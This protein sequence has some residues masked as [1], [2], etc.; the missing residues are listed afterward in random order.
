M[1][2]PAIS[3]PPV[4]YQST[5]ARI[6]LVYRL[7]TLP[8]ARRTL[9]LT[10]PGRE[11]PVVEGWDGEVT[12]D[13]LGQ[14]VSRLARYADQS[15]DRVVL[16]WSLDQF[17]ASPPRRRRLAARRGVL[18]HVWRILVPRGV[19]AGCVP[20]LVTTSGRA[21][22]ALFGSSGRRWQ[23]LLE[24]EGFERVRTLIELPSG[25]APQVLVGID[26][27][28]SQHY[29]LLDLERSKNKL[30]PASRLLRRVLALTGVTRHLQGS[31][32]FSGRRPC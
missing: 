7:A 26:R 4:A 32:V 25:D 2:A 18:R 1:E 20:N 21:G 31:I 5:A 30:P 6:S 19:I 9:L 28:P 11:L 16:H 29:F 8:A 23:S 3:A 22:G 10:V 27:V 15:F 14:D 17:V 12:L 24:A 13:Y